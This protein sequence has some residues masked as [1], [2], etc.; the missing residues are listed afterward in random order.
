MSSFNN[1][2]QASITDVGVRRG[3][4]Q[5]HFAVLL[6]TDQEQWTTQGHVF[7]VA[8][9]MGAHAVGEKASEL[10]ANIIPH[11]YQKHA[12]RGAAS[13]LRKAFTEAN[14]TIHTLGQQ[15]REFKGLGTTA[16]ALVLRPDG[17]WVGHVGDSRVYRVRGERIDQLSFDHSLLWEHARHRNIDPEQITGVPSNRLLR[18]LGPHPTVLAD[19]EGPHP[20]H[21]ADI[22]VLCTDGLVNH[23]SDEEI[24]AV[25]RVLPPDEA[26]NFLVDLANLRGGS[27]NITIIVLRVHELGTASSAARKQRQAPKAAADSPFPWPLISLTIGIVTAAVSTFITSFQPAVG[28][29]VFLLACALIVAGIVGLVLQYRRDNS[30]PEDEE[31]E[32]ASKPKTYR[33]ASCRIDAQLLDKLSADLHHLGQQAHEKQWAVDWDAFQQQRGLAVNLRSRG[34][35]TA[36]FRQSCQTLRILTQALRQERNKEE[37]FHPVWDKAKE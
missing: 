12:G 11:S 16:T 28:L 14:T 9:G 15:N 2:E 3:H 21:A 17:A 5:D 22:F 35:E 24:G 6:A 30:P 27:D 33:R 26:C 8:D 20:V 23:V 29:P 1:V 7:L 32:P 36:A 4:N 19:V 18:S 31:E 37:A 10:A 25:A 34:D 13:A